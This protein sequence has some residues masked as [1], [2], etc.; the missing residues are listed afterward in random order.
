VK[1]VSGKVICI[2]WPN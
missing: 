1:T 2:H